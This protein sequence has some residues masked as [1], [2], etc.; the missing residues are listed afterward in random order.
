[1]PGQNTKPEPALDG[2]MAWLITSVPSFN[3]TSVEMEGLTQGKAADQLW[4]WNLPIDE[5]N[6]SGWESSPDNLIFQ[7]HLPGLEGVQIST[8]LQRFG[9]NW[10]VAWWWMTVGFAIIIVALFLVVRFVVRRVF[11]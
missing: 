1:K 8:Q 6:L 5:N 4:G 2:L 3:E 9:H 10:Q 7:P 11:H